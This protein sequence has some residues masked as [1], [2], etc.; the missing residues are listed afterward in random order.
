MSD[1]YIE[2]RIK[3]AQNTLKHRQIDC[4]L[5]VS[6][7]NVTYFTGF[8]GHDSWAVITPKHTYLLTDSRYTEQADKE[9]PH[10]RILERTGSMAQLAYGLTKRSRCIRTLHVEDT[11]SC[12]QFSA[13][14][15]EVSVP[16]KTTASL[17]SL[18]M[19]KDAHESQLIRKAVRIAIS[20]FEQ[21]I[22]CIEPGI[23]EFELA[24]LLDYHIHKQGAGNA[25]D[26]IVAFGANGSRPHHQPGSRKLKTNDAILMDFGARYQGYCSD[27]TRSFSI[28]RPPKDFIRA[29]DA[30]L[31]AQ[32]AA[33]QTIKPNAAISDADQT[34]RRVIKNNGFPVYGHGTGHGIG[35]DIHEGPT[36]NANNS[37]V[38]QCGQIVTIEPGIYLPGQ[39]GIR[40]E[41]DVIVATNKA[42]VLTHACAQHAR[43]EHYKLG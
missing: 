22:Q 6:P 24:A 39:F 20:A 28:G 13:L 19:V 14:Q 7:A 23:R 11:V 40:I 15:K 5:L 26:T 1:I 30:V 35:L 4:L 27:I 34:A 41:E 8:M 31:Q 16:V 9:C 18:R 2:Q 32:Q 42:H 43:L 25:F 29:Y 17:T 38:F 21:T 3:L 33:I 12:A 37:E 36:L 10:C